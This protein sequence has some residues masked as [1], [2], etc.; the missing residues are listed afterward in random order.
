MINRKLQ[1][2]SVLIISLLLLIIMTLLG[3]SSM[4]TTVME[5]R[6]AGNLRNSNL[7][8]MAAES[9]LREAEEIITT[10]DKNT[11]PDARNDGADGIWL[12]DTPD[13]DY[14]G[15]S[16]EPTGFWWA[17]NDPAWWDTTHLSDSDKVGKNSST[18]YDA[19]SDYVAGAGDKSL[20]GYYVIEYIEPVCD[21]LTVGQQSDQQSCRDFFQATSMG[22]GPGNV[23]RSYVRTTFARR[24]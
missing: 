8:F 21:T 20:D 19:G 12:I 14:D 17:T 18:T 11:R 7:A 24:F 4:N 5:E 10:F 3:L 15:T 22:Q 13:E 9:A 6:M 2:G 1:S 16:G 23:S